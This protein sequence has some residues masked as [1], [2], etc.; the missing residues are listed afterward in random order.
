MEASNILILLDHPHPK[1]LLLE[2]RNTEDAS[3]LKATWSS[4]LHD[5]QSRHAEFFT[6]IV[7]T[8]FG[9]VAVVS[10]YAGK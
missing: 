10:C 9:E 2:Y 6:D 7:T 5:R 3:L 1:L 8:T 4:D